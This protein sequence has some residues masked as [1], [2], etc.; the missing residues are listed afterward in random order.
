MA[1][2]SSKRIRIWNTIAYVAAGVLVC[3][4]VITLW[5]PVSWWL[6]GEEKYDEAALEEWVKEARIQRSLPELIDDYLEKVEKERERVKQQKQTG[7]PFEI[8]D[9][10]GEV[11]NARKD[12]HDFLRAL[13]DPVTKTYS[14]QLPLF[15]A[16]YQL[17]ITFDD[18]WDLPPIV[19]DSELPR[20]KEQFRTSRPIPI[21]ERGVHVR[22]SYRLRVYSYNQYSEKEEAARRLRLSGLATIMISLVFFWVYLA[23]RREKERQNQQFVAEQQVNEAERRR[24]EE[25]LKRREAEQLHEELERAN[26]ELKSQLWANIGIMAG[27]YAHN[28][29]NLL[30]RP[31]DLLARSMEMP[32]M[33]NDHGED[34]D[35]GEG[36]VGHRNR[37]FATNLAHRATRPDGNSQGT[38]RPQCIVTAIGGYLERIGKREMEDRPHT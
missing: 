23:H 21:G 20:Q 27:S 15:P 32:G 29:K 18:K 2:T 3:T 9:P 13:C 31:N 1:A 12:I 24:L 4:L 22:M 30:V 10:L 11:K 17:R 16:I 34:V 14:S 28:I 7:S 19:W 35:R 5:E 38:T 25:Q 33:S 8:V 36:N 6:Q 37:T 26:L